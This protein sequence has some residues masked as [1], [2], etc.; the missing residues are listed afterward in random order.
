ME[1]P[2]P[3]GITPLPVLLLV[4]D[5][6]GDILLIRRAFRRAGVQQRIQSVTMGL[7][8]VAEGDSFL[9]QWPEAGG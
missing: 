5:S 4:E 1:K 8:V 7:E 2:G 3:R 9:Y 6:R